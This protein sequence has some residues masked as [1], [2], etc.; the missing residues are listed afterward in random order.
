MLDETV[1]NKL[2]QIET[3]YEQINELMAQPE[4]ATDIGRLQTLVR[5]QSQ[6]GGV[7]AKYRH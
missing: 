4:V 2:A 5:E 7:V 6:I 1:L 3:R